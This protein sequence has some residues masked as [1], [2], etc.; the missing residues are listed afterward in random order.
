MGIDALFLAVADDLFAA[1]PPAGVLGPHFHGLHLFG[2]D[3][4]HGLQGL[5]LLVADA[6][7]VEGDRRL[8]E[9][10]RQHLHDVVLHD[11]AQGAGL[12]VE[13]APMADAE[14][15]ADG[16]LD[17]V[18]V[19]AV[20]DRLVDGVG[21]AQGEDVLDRLLPEVVVDAVHLLL[22]EPGVHD[23]VEVAR[24]RPVVPVRL[25]DDDAHERVVALRLVQ[26]VL[27]QRGDDDGEGRRRRREVVE[28]VL[29]G[30][31]LLVELVEHLLEAVERCLFVVVAGDVAEA[32]GERV[33][34]VLGLV[35]AA[36][37][38]LHEGA[39]ALAE[40]VVV[41]LG[42]GDADHR[43]PAGEQA[44]QGQACDGGHELAARQVSR[45]PEDH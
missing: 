13:A 37:E 12:L 14:R 35:A 4:L 10:H 23:R 1:D 21:E 16:D 41:H 7:G 22:G 36:T 30:A 29:R 11:V 27:A 26:A 18:D 40:V 31:P 42:A 25:L 39:H 15:F 20:P 5:D 3:N 34:H 2:L 19:A 9:R 28:P 17:V 33:P 45:R 6:V 24:A 43:E 44:A 8:H 38:G 32:A